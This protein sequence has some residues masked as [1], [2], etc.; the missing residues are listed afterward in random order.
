[1]S[2]RTI[3]WTKRALRRLDQVGQ[4]IAKDSPDAAASVVARIAASVE[5][6]AEQPA[7][8]RPGRITGTRELVLVDVP[9]IV[10]YRVARSDI[11]IL[12]VMHTAQKWPDSL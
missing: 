4:H 6:L 2:R 9:Y 1:M 8:G 11:E 12:T 3:R 7:I 10:P 5:L